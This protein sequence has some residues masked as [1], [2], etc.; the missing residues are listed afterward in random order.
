M[1]NTDQIN[2]N[3]LFL[4]D[5]KDEHSLERNHT[6]FLLLDD[7]NYLSQ[8]IEPEVDKISTT[9]DSQSEECKQSQN[10]LLKANLE[11]TSIFFL[12][13]IGSEYGRFRHRKTKFGRKID[14]F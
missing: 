9:N 12:I 13:R 3:T 2:I 14:A 10:G 8:Y 4:F 1:P 5:D 7:G 6:H 11:S